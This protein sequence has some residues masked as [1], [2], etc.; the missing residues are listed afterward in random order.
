MISTTNSSREFLRTLLD[1]CQPGW[2]LPGAFYHDEIVYRLDLERIWRR[3]WL[4]AG[5][6]CEIPEPGDYFTVEVDADSIIIIR[7]D[8]GGIRGFHNVCRHRGSLIC[9]EPTGHVTRFVCPYHQWTYGRDG[10]L[11]A[12]RGMQ[13]DLD[14]TQLDLA[15]VQTREV[16]GLIFLSLADKP[17]AFALANQ[18]LS[19]SAKRQGFQR[20]KVAK[21]VD[22]LVNANWK[23]VW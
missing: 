3:G 16:E 11:L 6:S 8:D 9:T 7:N 20:A 19:S 12:C 22:Y 18:L 2:S 4:F 15:P 21:S 13:E 14:K 1:G 10:Q 23:L 17:P 5:H